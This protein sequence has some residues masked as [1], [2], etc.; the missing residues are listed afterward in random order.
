MTQIQI[1]DS[2]RGKIAELAQKY[3]LSLVVL[4]GSQSRG[5][6]HSKSDVDIAYRG[7][8]PLLL[9]SEGMLIVELIEVFHTDKIDLVL[10][11]TV[12]P[13]AQGAPFLPAVLEKIKAFI[14]LRKTYKDSLGEPYTP[15]CACDGHVNPET[16]PLLKAAGVEIFNVGSYFSKAPDLRK[17]YLELQQSLT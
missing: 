17:A 14:E 13:G 8:G 4:F 15:L 6:T 1:T 9:E 2:I 16:A 5:D 7:A 11:M 10:F 3:H 12:F